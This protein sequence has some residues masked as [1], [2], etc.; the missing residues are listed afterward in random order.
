MLAV[1]NPAT[2][3]VI[4]EGRGTKHPGSFIMIALMRTLYP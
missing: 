1:M 2:T 3:Y 4:G